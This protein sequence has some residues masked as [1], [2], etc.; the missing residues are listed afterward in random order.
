MPHGFA[1]IEAGDGTVTGI[2]PRQMQQG[3]ITTQAVEADAA[4]A[5]SRF[6]YER[7]A[8]T[9]PGVSTLGEISRIASEAAGTTVVHCFTYKKCGTTKCGE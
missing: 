9:V 5:L 2:Y 1:Y 7:K 8:G 6:D 4:A 3:E